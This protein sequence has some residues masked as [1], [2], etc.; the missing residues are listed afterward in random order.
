MRDT[1]RP[2]RLAVVVV[3]LATLASACGQAASHSIS[4]SSSQTL[5]RALPTTVPTRPS[6]T[7]VASPVPTSTPIASGNRSQ[8]PTPADTSGVEAEIDGVSQILAEVDR[9][10]SDADA[11]LSQNEGDVNP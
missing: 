4:G 9:S 1:V 3:A 11:G 7:S 10:L 6:P 5:L 2:A 8:T